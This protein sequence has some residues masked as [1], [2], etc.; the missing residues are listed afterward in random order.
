[1]AKYN[2]APDLFAYIRNIERRV[3]SLERGVRAVPVPIRALRSSDYVDVAITSGT[4]VDT[5]F[6]PTVFL[7]PKPLVTIAVTCTDGTTAGEFRLTNEAGTPL[8]G[9]NGETITSKVIPL[10]TT[11]E[12]VFTNDQTPNYWARQ[13]VGTDFFV[14]L[15]VR[16]TAGTGTINVKA[17]YLLQ[18]P[19]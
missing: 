8:T 4:F 5:H 19:G 17:K 2:T 6:F 18:V 12:T 16:R 9:P 11:I 13:A 14:K 10:G 3:E 15:Q 1:M 7:A